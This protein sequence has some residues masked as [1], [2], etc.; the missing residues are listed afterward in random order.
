MCGICG[1]F[2]PT[3]RPPHDDFEESCLQNTRSPDPATA[4]TSRTNR[5]SRISLIG[6]GPGTDRHASVCLIPGIEPSQHHR[7]LADRA[8]VRP[9]LLPRRRPTES[10]EGTR[11]LV[12]L[13]P[14][15]SKKLLQNPRGI[16]L[17]FHRITDEPAPRQ[18]RGTTCLCQIA[19]KMSSTSA[20]AAP[21]LVIVFAHREQLPEV[22]L[23][24]GA[25]V[26]SA[27]PTDM[28]TREAAAFSTADPTRCHHV[29]NRVFWLAC[30]CPGAAGWRAG[31]CRAPA[32]S[33]RG[34]PASRRSDRR[35]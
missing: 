4:E 33:C 24:C 34:S 1:M 30:A 31:W 21:V 11:L 29:L 3:L 25:L 10:G 7:T 22:D 17:T 6:N 8:L 26:L 14:P 18:R 32:G 19:C 23:L 28:S 2:R 35:G 5:T 16:S 13:R 12:P 15:A 20:S 9:S 27:L